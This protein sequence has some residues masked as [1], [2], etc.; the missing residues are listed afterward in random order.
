MNER[1]INKSSPNRK[2]INATN[3]KDSPAKTGK[4]FEL[5][6]A[7]KLNRTQS[8]EVLNPSPEP[9]LFEDG[10]E[11]DKKLDDI[12]DVWEDKLE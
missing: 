3:V 4:A 8:N 11:N 7:D 12:K 10:Q 1:F 5:D 9:K 2:K 6:S